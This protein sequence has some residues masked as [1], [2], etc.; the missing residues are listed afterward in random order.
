MK[1]APVLVLTRRDVA[2]LL[3]VDA[4]IAAVEEAFRLQGEGR[5]PRAGVLG[6]PAGDGGFHVKAAAL[7]L[8]R[9]Y[10]AAKINGNYS[11]NPKRFG[12]PAVQGVVALCDA[13]NGS[14]L[15]LMDSI[16]ITILRTGATTAVAARHLARPDSRVVTICGCGNQGRSQLRALARVLPIETVFAYDMDPETAHA[17][18][19]DLSRELGIRIEAVADPAAAARSSDVCVTCTPSRRFFLRRADVP[20][21]AFVA[22]VGADA[23]DKQELEPAVLAAGRL[24]V[25]SLDQCATIGELHHAL[26]DGILDRGAVEAELSEI[27]AGRKTGRTSTEEIVVFDSTGIALEDVAAAAVV[28][29]RACQTGRGMAVELG[30]APAS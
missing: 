7:D 26:E 27:V 29:E 22:A 5:A 4:C 25:D 13:E 15:A 10:F 19:R 9:P 1:P 24:V 12:L 20:A 17:F 11:D 18:A 14:P 21:G 28:Y 2:Q 8:S 23:A 3:D 30:A 16:E 6:Y